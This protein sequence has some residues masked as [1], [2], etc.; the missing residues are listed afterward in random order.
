M[1]AKKNSFAEMFP[2]NEMPNLCRHGRAQRRWRWKT[3][4]KIVYNACLKDLEF[5]RLFDTYT[6]FQEISMFLGGLAVPLKEIPHVPDKIMVGAKGFDQ[7]SF[8]KPPQRG[9]EQRENN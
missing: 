2:K 6:A 7:W 3:Q 9:S 8:R 5:F 1:R 4:A